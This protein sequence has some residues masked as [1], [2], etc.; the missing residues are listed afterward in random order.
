MRGHMPTAPALPVSIAEREE[1]ED[2]VRARTVPQVL[3]K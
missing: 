1:L 3:V 2:L